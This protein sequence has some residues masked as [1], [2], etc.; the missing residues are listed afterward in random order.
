MSNQK[1]LKK[2]WDNYYLKSKDT[3]LKDKYFFQLEIDALNKEVKKIINQSRQ[4]EYKIL[5]IGCGTGVLAKEIIKNNYNVKL[6]YIGVDLSPKAIKT[7]ERRKISFCHFIAEDIITFLKNT[8]KGSFDIILS[9]R[10]IMA[11][12]TAEE[13]KE[14]FRL[15][16]TAKKKNG[17]GIFSE[18]IKES[19]LKV[20]RLR[21]EISISPLTKIWH[22]RH[23]RV[24]ELKKYFKKIELDDFSS[25]YWLITRVIYPYFVKDIKHNS[26][27]AKFSSKLEQTGNYSMVKLIKVI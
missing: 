18:V 9:Q 3:A 22:S 8:E 17:I 4:K 2:V 13:H 20:N 12:L 27:I 23:L 16:N 24:S 10:S 26:D 6:K 14:L 15:I 21:K 5:E 25:T 19:Y 11:L 1:K 7:A